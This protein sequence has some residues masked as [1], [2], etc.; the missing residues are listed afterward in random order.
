MEKYTF[1]G[2]QLP[3]LLT[4]V[5]F[6]VLNY[7]FIEEVFGDL[8]G[9]LA[10]IKWVGGIGLSVACVFLFI[11]LNRLLSKHLFQDRVFREERY[12]PS[13][14]FLLYSN[15]TLS[16]QYKEAIRAKILSDFNIQLLGIEEEQIAEE[17]ARRTIVD[18]VGMIRTATRTSNLLLQHNYEYGF[19][20]NF[21]GGSVAS[22]ILCLVGIVL[23]SLL[24]STTAVYIF[25]VLLL[26]YLLPIIFHRF[27]LNHLAQSY[28]KVLFQEFLA[29]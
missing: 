5:P 3:A 22:I 20:R 1:Y 24:S 21:L 12:F 17:E 4:A 23:G 11:Q 28:A 27:I 19:V 9:S 10:A 29:R 16:D 26:G 8:L 13:T 7:Y 2:R 25:S 15:T 14:S 18:A 6:F